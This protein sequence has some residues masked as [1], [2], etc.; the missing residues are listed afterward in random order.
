MAWTGRGFCCKTLSSTGRYML[1]NLSVLSTRKVGLK[2]SN[3]TRGP[4][5]CS[6]R[7][8]NLFV[9]SAGAQTQVRIVEIAAASCVVRPL[10][11]GCG[12]CRSSR[13][14]V[15]ICA[16]RYGSGSLSMRRS[17]PSHSSSPVN[18]RMYMSVLLR[19]GNVLYLQALEIRRE[20]CQSPLMWLLV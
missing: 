19:T 8:F 11:V 6:D 14:P 1:R 7:H 18:G 4:P 3:R 13:V 17:P 10:R 16:G 5:L 2:I 20:G 15:H 12:G 9:A